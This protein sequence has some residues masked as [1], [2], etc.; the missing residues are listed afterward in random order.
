MKTITKS[1]VSKF[2]KQTGHYIDHETK[3]LYV[4]K[5]FARKAKQYGTNECAMM[6]DLMNLCYSVEVFAPKREPRLTY[7]M[8]EV[9][10]SKMPNAEERFETYRRVR[11]ESVI[12][13]NRYKHVLDWFK[14]EFPYYKELTVRD[15]KGN[16][17]W[18]AVK[19]YE[20]AKLEEQIRKT[21]GNIV[22]LPAAAQSA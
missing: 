9:F 12:M 6:D 10:I 11:L 22:S 1:T 16:L 21:G 2:L 15:E 7:A 13:N 4:S 17:V 14:N 3:T 5:E 18:D 20:Q 8:M 19:Q